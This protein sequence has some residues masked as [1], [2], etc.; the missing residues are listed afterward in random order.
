MDTLD[1][2]TYK[3]DLQPHKPNTYPLPSKL[4]TST[5]HSRL[6]HMAS[7]HEALIYD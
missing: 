3:P 6:P 4:I 5:H 2:A 1:Q 7:Y